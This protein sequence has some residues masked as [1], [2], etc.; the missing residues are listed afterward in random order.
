MT[1]DPD[2]PM[3]ILPAGQDGAADRSG[4]GASSDEAVPAGFDWNDLRYFLE[5][6]RSGSAKA[7]GR[8]LRADHTTVRR[9]LQLLETALGAR[10][11]DSQS[12]IYQLTEAGTHL[13]QLA[14]RVESLALEAQN[15]VADAAHGV[16]GHVGIGAPEGFGT[17]YLAPRIPA[18]LGRHPELR[19][20]LVALPRVFNLS[21]READIAVALTPPNQQKQIVRKLTGYRLGLY[22][23]KRY[24]ADAAPI[25]RLS[26][27]KTHVFVGYIG[28][29]LYSA[30]LDY[31]PELGFPVRPAFESSSIM[32]QK[33]AIECGFGVGILPHFLAAATP[34][35]LPVLP[36]QLSLDRNFWLVVHPE[37]VNL[38]RVRTVIDH[39]VDMVQRDRALFQGS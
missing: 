4:P 35:L 27:L 38:I 30:E 28:E 20:G 3:P 25:R 10:L 7:A 2:D 29:L 22:A 19:L 26:D 36:D 17:E 12:G 23:S 14:E 6:A 32:A 31:L 1:R 8:R 5:L 39:I 24:L 21:K 11:L 15:H 9:R 34:D 16:S 18:L 13:L 33:R 37:V